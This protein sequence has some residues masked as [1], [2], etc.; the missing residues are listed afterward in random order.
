MTLDL[1]LSGSTAR[2][3]I[4]PSQVDH[5]YALVANL[6][7]ADRLEMTGL[8]LDPRAVIRTSYRNGIMRR[9]AFVDGKI[10]A[11][12]G[13]GG[14]ML[15]DEGSPWLM[16]TPMVE[17]VPVSFLRVARAQVAEMLSRRQRL[18]N[19]VQASYTGACRLLEHLG[20]TLSDPEP[21]G[22][23]AVP[24]RRFT[25]TRID[26]TIPNRVTS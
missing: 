16:T 14:V 24:F 4:V 7:D 12:W 22:P 9:T 19:V 6:R 11:M 1:L 2:V 15:S 21:L 10:A 20:F 17:R 26:A 8:D 13:L 3:H 23:H 5:V 25:M 18:S